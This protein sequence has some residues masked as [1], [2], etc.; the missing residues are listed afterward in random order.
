MTSLMLPP[1]AVGIEDTDGPIR[2]FAEILHAYDE[3]YSLEYIPEADVV[4]ATVD[5]ILKPY[6]IVENTPE[7]GRQVVRYLTADEL[8]RPDRLLSWI[9]EGDLRKH[10]PS[11]VYDR[12][13]R[14]E[15]ARKILE[16]AQKRD[17]AAAREDFAAFMIRTPKNRIQLGRNRYVNV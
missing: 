9:W 10:S 15:Q 1:T 5:E 6:R 4:N 2:R 13:E 7:F 17:E 12:I 14:E 11:A 16:L 3:R 8:K